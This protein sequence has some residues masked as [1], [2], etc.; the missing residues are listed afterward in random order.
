MEVLSILIFKCKSG[1]YIDN[2]A[3]HL[4]LLRFS[5]ITLTP[6]LILEIYANLL[7]LY[8]PISL[9][10]FNM[11]SPPFPCFKKNKGGKCIFF[12]ME[13]VSVIILKFRGCEYNLPLTIRTEKMLS[14]WR[15]AFPCHLNTCIPSLSGL[16]YMERSS[17]LFWPLLK[18]WLIKAVCSGYTKILLAPWCLIFASR[19]GSA[20]TW[21]YNPKI[22]VDATILMTLKLHMMRK[23]RLVCVIC[24][25]IIDFNWDSLRGQVGVGKCEKSVISLIIRRVSRLYCQ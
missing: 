10:L 20:Y 3:S 18:P 5:V 19:I 22:N 14:I 9:S 21:W 15:N 25:V 23:R 12:K 13:G 6:P 8:T 16:W 2:W 11:D 1:N 24:N 4:S 7:F 17:L